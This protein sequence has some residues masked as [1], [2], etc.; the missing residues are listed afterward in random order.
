MTEQNYRSMFND[1]LGRA[2]ELGEV[3]KMLNERAD[4]YIKQA[5]ELQDRYIKEGETERSADDP[6][7]CPVCHNWG[8]PVSITGTRPVL[9]GEESY[10]PRCGA[11]L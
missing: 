9:S 5:E 10:C 11:T 4:S 8:V 7:R 3:T 2:R 1:L 6:I